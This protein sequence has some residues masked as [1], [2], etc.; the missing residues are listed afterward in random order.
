MNVLGYY[1]VFLDAFSKYI[2]IYLLQFKSQA[3]SSCTQFKA[4]AKRQL[5]VSLKAIQTDNAKE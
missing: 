2:W 5:G 4:S 1:I 3:F